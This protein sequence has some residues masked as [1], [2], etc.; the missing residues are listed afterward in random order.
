[1]ESGEA[2][3]SSP[4]RTFEERGW[5]KGRVIE[6]T[7]GADVELERQSLGR[8]KIPVGR[9]NNLYYGALLLIVGVDEYR[10]LKLDRS[11]RVERRT[12]FCY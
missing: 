9:G 8:A 4:A 6:V 1:M 12:F 3:I 11:R 7:T 2:L 5:A 10:G